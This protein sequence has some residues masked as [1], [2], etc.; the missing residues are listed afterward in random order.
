MV[1]SV[2]NANAQSPQILFLDTRPPVEVNGKQLAF[3]WAGGLN[4][5]IINQIELNGDGFTDILIFDRVGNRIITFLNDGLA[6][7]SSYS[8]APQ[9]QQLFPRLHDWVR[10]ADFDC[11]GDFDLFT[12]G[13]NAMEVY[14]NDFVSGSGLS[15]SLFTNQVNSNYGTLQAPIF[16]SQA[17]MP[18]IVDMDADGDL[19]IL[20]FANSSNYV[21]YHKNYSMDSTGVCGGFNFTL[22]P[23]C[24]GYFKLSGLT[25]IALLNQNCRLAIANGNDGT[26]V[27]RSRHSGSVLTAFDQGCD[28]D[29]DVINGDIL[30]QN[31][32][33]LENGGTQDSAYITAQDSAFPSYDVN[34]NL[35]NLPAAYYLD[36]DN[37]GAKDLIVTPY[38]TVGEDLQNVLWYRNTTDNCSNV[39]NFIKSRF[40]SE[41]MIDVGTSSNPVFF[42][43]DQ[44]GLLDIISGNDIYYNDNPNLSVSR[45]AYFRNVGTATQPAFDL[46]TDDWLNLSTFNQYGLVP[47]FGDLD[48]DGDADM[49]LGNADGNLIYFQNTAASGSPANFVFNQPVYQGI[50]IGNNSTP[51]IIDINRDGKN[52]LLIGERLGVLNYY[53]NT[54]TAATP[55]FTLVT[56]N[57]GSVNVMKAGAIAGYSA[58]V[59]YDNAGAYE[60]I[61]G[62]ESG[63]IYQYGNIDGNLAGAFNL[64]DSMYQGIYEPKRVTISRAD[65]DGDSKADLITGNNCGGFRLYTQYTAIG[66]AENHA[67]LGLSIWP[68]PA[69]SQMYVQFET[70]VNNQQR[71]IEISDVLGKIIYRNVCNDLNTTIDLS[72]VPSGMYLIKAVHNGKQMVQKFIRK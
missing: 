44:D 35:Q 6:S 11:D 34:V 31:L 33:F 27:L 43:V 58:P 38:A 22:E 65:I 24:W 5:P 18:A 63:Y 2:W 23:Y 48:G 62:S 57:F 36:V 55:V 50:D 49:L 29:M 8:W 12:Y 32:L 68:N 64:I 67:A 54:G 15:F 69:E 4:S 41:D 20:T 21:E 40:L 53:Q 42:D 37:D 59:L 60:L 1:I 47:S 39:F 52:D 66:V 7:Q 70:S 26:D 30:G 9:Y 16:V 19:D 45:L 10:T 14:R 46:I 61:V 71:I 17:N 13:N 56:T 25:N 72:Q 51:Q 28:G 3:P